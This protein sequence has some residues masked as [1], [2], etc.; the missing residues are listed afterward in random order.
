MTSYPREG[1]AMIDEAGELDFSDP[2]SDDFEALSRDVIP[3]RSMLPQDLAAVVDID[4]REMGRARRAYYERMFHQMFEV[5]G[6]RVSLVAELDD[7][8]VGFVMARVDYGEF[9]RTEPTAVMDTIGVHPDYRNLQVATALMSQLLVN[10]KALQVEHVRTSVSWRNVGLI[11]FL[12]D[13]GFRPAQ[14][15]ALSRPLPSWPE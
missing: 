3:V 5:A 14:R 9:G 11:G 6:V 12:A 4:R 8:V 7:R 10:L 2:R 13:A 1:E 15:L